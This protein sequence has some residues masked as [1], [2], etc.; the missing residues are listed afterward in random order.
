MT[1]AK[2]VLRLLQAKARPDQLDGMIRYGMAPERR[3]GVA[4]PELR[5][6]ARQ[7]G[8][9]HALASALWETKIP[10]AMMLAS[11]IGDPAQVTGRE[12][13][14]WVKDFGSWDVCDQVCMNLFEKTPLAWK[15]AAQ[16]SVREE[17]FTRRAA[18]ALMACLAWHA[19]D[20]PDARF[21][22]FIPWIKRA[23][24]DDRGMVKKGVSWALRNMGKRSP[25]LQRVVLAAAREIRGM[26]TR[27]A[28]WIASDVMRDL[29]QHGAKEKLRR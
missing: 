13:E 20:A 12:M 1:T 19:E 3:L 9:D 6:I 27:S 23:A 25:A 21:V 24:N 16:W 17:E 4:V 15:K 14:E 11:M 2:E 26:D 22:K 10:D 29:Q 18:F 8:K 28:R 5:R 7:V